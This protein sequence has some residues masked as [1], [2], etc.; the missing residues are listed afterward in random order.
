MCGREMALREG[1][2]EAFLW[3]CLFS[4]QDKTR[5]LCSRRRE[6]PCPPRLGPPANR[7]PRLFSAHASVSA[8]SG[9]FFGPLKQPLVG[10]GISGN[11]GL[12]P[13]E[14]VPWPWAGATMGC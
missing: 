14:L 7:A 6:N 3:V 5:P 12:S 1:Q 11:P 13:P 10:K 8:L 4:L 9:L 2:H